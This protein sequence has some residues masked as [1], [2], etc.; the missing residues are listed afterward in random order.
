MNSCCA[1]R[2]RDRLS[3]YIAELAQELRSGLGLTAMK[4]QEEPRGIFKTL[5]SLH[6]H[7]PMFY[8][9]TERIMTRCDLSIFGKPPGFVLLRPQL[10]AS[11]INGERSVESSWHVLLGKPLIADL[12]PIAP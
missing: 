3:F 1:W 8:S 9:L 7:V 6:H 2:Q 5:A 4:A 10:K 12:R 11:S